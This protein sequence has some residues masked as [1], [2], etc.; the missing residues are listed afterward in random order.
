MPDSIEPFKAT[1]ADRWAAD[2]TSS[3][4]VRPEAVA[5][6]AS[7]R[8]AARRLKTASTAAAKPRRRVVR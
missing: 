6:A 8:V 1:G 3:A 7:G 4:Y 2:E 5:A